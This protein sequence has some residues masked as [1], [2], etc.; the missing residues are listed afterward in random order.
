M[1]ERRG[2]KITVNTN[3]MREKKR[4]QEK[5]EQLR[6]TLTLTSLLSERSD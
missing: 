3:K 4:A 6:L 1:R 5:N 2:K